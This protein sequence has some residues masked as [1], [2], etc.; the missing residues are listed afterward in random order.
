MAAP[1]A[2]EAAAGVSA[3]AL[4]IHEHHQEIIDALQTS[5]VVIVVGETGSGMV[6]EGPVPAP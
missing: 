5:Q 2:P 6:T 1:S 3:A 4:P